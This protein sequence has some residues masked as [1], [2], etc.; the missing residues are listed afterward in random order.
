M[1]LVLKARSVKIPIL[2]RGGIMVERCAEP[3]RRDQK[4]NH[5]SAIVSR[6][7]RGGEGRMD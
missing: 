7:F 2:F 3:V 4:C 1:T 5:F 6:H